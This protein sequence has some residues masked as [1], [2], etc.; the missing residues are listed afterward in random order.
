MLRIDI[1]SYKK[2]YED[3]VDE[4][5]KVIGQL[6]KGIDY[7]DTKEEVIELSERSR[8]YLDK[9]VEFSKEKNISPFWK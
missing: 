7:M 5:G 9:I 3:K 1:E 4:E 8:K 6:Y 2:I